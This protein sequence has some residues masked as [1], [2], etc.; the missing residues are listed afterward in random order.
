MLDGAEKSRTKYDSI[1]N[2]ICLLSSL[3][4]MFAYLGFFLHILHTCGDLFTQLLGTH[5]PW[6]L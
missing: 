3:V 1:G 5:Q 4:P 6:P 2:S